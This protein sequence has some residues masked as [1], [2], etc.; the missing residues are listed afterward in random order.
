MNEETSENQNEQAK[1]LAQ[2]R[3][4]A[5]THLKT[6]LARLE[7]LIAQDRISKDKSTIISKKYA[8]IEI[9]Y[10]N[11]ISL[12]EQYLET[13]DV[14]NLENSC[15]S[16]CDM[17]NLFS[18]TINKLHEYQN[19][20]SNIPIAEPT[21]SITYLSNPVVTKPPIFRGNPEDFHSWLESFNAYC[22]HIS[23][24]EDKLIC[25][26]RFTA[27]EPLG[28]VEAF[29]YAP[30]T[31]KTFLDALTLLK[32]T[33]GSDDIVSDSII[34]KLEN[35]PKIKAND[36]KSL[37]LYHNILVQAL[38]MMS[39]YPSLGILNER[40]Q[41]KRICCKL[42]N[43]LQD[44]WVEKIIE[45]APNFPSF[46][47]FVSFIE[48]RLRVTNN[49]MRQFPQQT[50][51]SCLASGDITH[52][53]L[54]KP[55]ST[56]TSQTSAH[57]P[58]KTF[59]PCAVCSST[60]HSVGFCP[61]F[62]EKP[63]RERVNIVKTHNLCNNCLR[64]GH[65][66]SVCKSPYTCKVC[67]ERHHTL[68]HEYNN[69][70]NSI[71]LAGCSS[72]QATSM[73]TILPVVVSHPL[74]KKSITVFALLDSQSNTNF[75]SRRIVD[76]LKIPSTT[77]DLTL[78]TMSGIS[79]STSNIVSNISIHGVGEE[80]ILNLPQCHIKDN[81]PCDRSAIPNQDYIS[82]YP[83]LSAVKLPP[84]ATGAPIGLLLGY[85]MS[86]AF[87]PI[88]IARKDIESPYATKTPLGWCV[89]GHVP[90]DSKS[91]VYK[92]M[93]SIATNSSKY[94]DKASH[95]LP[96]S[97]SENDFPND[98]STPMPHI[99]SK[100]LSNT[101]PGLC[102]DSNSAHLKYSQ[103][104]I[105][106]LQIMETNMKQ[107]KNG[108]YEAPLPLKFE[109]PFPNNRFT[110]ERRLQSLKSR[111][112][113]NEDYF[114][115]YSSV[116]QEM[117][118]SGYAEIAPVD[119]KPTQN[120]VWYLPHH[121]VDQG[122]LRIVFDCS[123]KLNGV[124]LN[125]RLL[126]GPD[127]LNSLLGILLRFRMNKIV[128]TCDIKK[129]YHQFSVPP[130]DRDL[131]RFLWFKNGDISCN[132]CEYRMC[133]HLFGATSS[134][135]VATFGLRKIASDFSYSYPQETSNFI[136]RD[137]YVDDG[138][139]SVNNANEAI[140]LFHSTKDLLSKGCLHCHKVMSNSREVLDHIS[141]DDLADS[142]NGEHKV[143]GL[144]W[145]TCSDSLSIPLSIQ[146][147]NVTRRSLLSALAKIYDPLGFAAPVTLCGKAILQEMCRL[148]LDWDDSPPKSLTKR[149]NE[150]Q[151]ITSATDSI[152]S[153][154]HILPHNVDSTGEIHIFCD[155]STIG[156][157]ACAYLRYKDDAGLFNVSFLIG[158]ARVAPLKPSLTI[159]RLELTAAALAVT[160]SLLIKR[161]MSFQ[162]SFSF[163]TDSSVVL[164][165]INNGSTRFKVFVAN[166]VSFILQ[167][168]D[169]SMWHHIPGSDNPADCGSR[170]HWSQIWLQGPPFLFSNLSS[171]SAQNYPLATDNC[172]VICLDTHIKKV[173][174]ENFPI[175]LTWFQTIRLWAW[176]LRFI[177]NALPNSQ[178][179]MSKVLSVTE[180]DYAKTK[181]LQVS[182]E[183][184]FKNE[185]RA[186]RKGNA[187]S[188]DSRL[189]RLDVFLGQD[190]LIRVGGRLR[191]SSFS[192]ELSHPIVIS[193]TCNLASK[194]IDHFHKKIHHQGRGMTIS[195]IRNNGYWILGLSNAVKKLV[196]GC[197]TCARLRGAPCQQKMADLPPERLLNSP[198]FTF[199]GCDLFGPFFI[200]QGRS[201]VKRWVVLFSCMCSRAIHLE[202]VHS[203]S[204]D[205]FIS[206]FK[207]LVAVRGPIRMIRCDQ[208]TN[209][210]GAEKTLSG[211]GCEMK[212]NPPSASH[213]G[214]HY[215]RL[216]GT[217]RRV[218]E[219]ILLEHSTLLVDESFVTLLSETTW[220]VNS[221][222][223]ATNSLGDPKSL[224]PLSANHILTQKSNIPCAVPADL[225][226]PDE[227]KYTR[228]QWKRVLYLASLF[229]SR[230]SREVVPLLQVR[231][232]WL[233]K[234]ENIK[235]DDIVMIVNDQEHRSHWK[236]ARVH[237]VETS[238][239]GL[240]RSAKLRL[241]DRSFL[242]RPVQKLVHL[243]ST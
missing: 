243:L 191:K 93:D 53:P 45:V 162:G 61:S 158:K 198:P 29:S 33:Y 141:P 205:S 71:A 48:K 204:T 117:I 38:H 241:S 190:G 140:N 10:N 50:N 210:I 128:L 233:R 155:A 161:E 150:W 231:Q 156:Y 56:V 167:N 55:S 34:A 194:I 1:T 232:K 9:L 54:L 23:T 42:P 5:I 60:Y 124:S 64:T 173:N 203:L 114:S 177:S 220:I 40:I 226:Q 195:E 20:K 68:M 164:S 145:N 192:Y 90:G 151:T 152:K 18:L 207:R 223:L 92:C 197:V 211:W 16:S 159:P 35:F 138:L 57:I 28:K 100:S 85:N 59:K 111:F 78:E 239:D 242:E 123:V 89:M 4:L 26:R 168:S 196:H 153:P 104:D 183:N 12:D 67:S 213:R 69:S 149:I 218:M 179:I 81:I 75:V 49:P 227:T 110:A 47:D 238:H 36:G 98:C 14:E 15:Q 234:R 108:H 230:Y 206:A 58:T 94:F 224:E 202:S 221:R 182:Q 76:F 228:T 175:L 215:E 163:W 157:A 229:W 188:V 199:I 236:L 212:F 122:K 120:R 237:S 181:L 74:S 160:L 119:K 107:C 235:V 3:G 103:D 32:E 102:S 2:K 63:L 139:I 97:H 129:M 65:A 37:N 17:N 121:S 113:K 96:E 22:R 70:N 209:F 142:K 51:A 130:E 106:F 132:P 25:L 180:L 146:I 39:D 101:S 147:Q 7:G 172:E 52:S 118:D 193:N 13:I 80:T 126:Q 174:C 116:M 169:H 6:S 127:Q 62:K 201:Q 225:N 30:K 115:R 24:V 137:F 186:L 165:Y 91:N 136:K 21:K 31:E 219:G 73:T 44:R 84:S 240:V 189:S 105:K 112:V 66:E 154:R 133:V 134:P 176:L 87:Y 171:I 11:F 99:L 187:V 109:K 46:K 135:G 148:R 216:I 144:N 170:G 27:D 82:L 88:E 217:A 166:K 185:L 125:E 19:S 131:L 41:N 200:K 208:G 222:P 79:K 43:S 77:V 83:H 214:G 143:L 178:R 95:S 72:N 86:Q 8:D 184:S